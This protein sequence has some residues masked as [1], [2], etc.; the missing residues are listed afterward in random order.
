VRHRA[1]A[2]IGYELPTRLG[3]FDLSL[4]QQYHSARSYNAAGVVDLRRIVTNPG[5]ITPPSNVRYYYAP[6]GSLRLDAVSSTGV[7]INFARRLGAYELFAEADIRNV[8]NAHAVEDPAGVNQ[9][10]RASN[11]DRNLVPFDPRTTT[12]IECPADVSTASAQCKGIANYQLS[13][14]FGQPQTKDAY[15]EPRTYGISLGVR[16]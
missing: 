3:R 13:K 15:Q 1:N 4:L 16:F 7:G 10:V 14:T 5:Y 8:F 9:I 2:W 12:P 6:R 11:I